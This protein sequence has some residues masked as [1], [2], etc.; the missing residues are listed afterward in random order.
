MFRKMKNI[1]TAFRHVRGFTLVV[2]TGCVV[3]SC[4]ALYKSFSLVSHAQNRVYILAKGKILEGVSS[5]RRANIPVEARDHVRVFHEYFFTLDPDEEVIK[6]HITKALYLAGGSAKQQYDNLRE[7]GY[8]TGIISGNISQRIRVDSVK[9]DV[10]VY[11]YAFT[12]YA[13]ER[14]IRSTSTAVRSLVTAGSLRTV[15]RSDHNPHGFLIEN[16][17]ILE[18]KDIKVIKH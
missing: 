4:F 1:D 2:I 15:S 12:C 11:P 16:W 6:A 13:T 17:V 3:V 9:V 7:S 18:N 14:L 10:S 5:A 8:Y